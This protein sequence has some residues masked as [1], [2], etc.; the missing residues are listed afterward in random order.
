MS[1]QPIFVYIGYG[2]VDSIDHEI[3]IEKPSS[4]INNRVPFADFDAT[5]YANNS[6][7]FSRSPQALNELI[8]LTEEMPL[9]WDSKLDRGTRSPVQVNSAQ[10]IKFF[11]GARLEK[12][13][14]AKHLG[15]NPNQTVDKTGKSGKQYKKPKRHGCVYRFFGIAAATTA[16]LNG[17]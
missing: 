1:Y 13:Y 8:T 10:H 3:D 15:F 16:A 4:I 14:G 7:L 12:K 5:C 2:L 6:I 17:R 9:Q 11:D